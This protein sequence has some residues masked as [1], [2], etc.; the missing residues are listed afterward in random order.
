V[1]AEERRLAREREQA[2]RQRQWEAVIE[3]AKRRFLADHRR[4]VLGKRVCAWQEAD[5]IRAYCDAVEV[6]YGAVIVATD[7][8]ASEWLAYAREHATL[9]QALPRTPADSDVSLEAF[10][11]YLCGLSP[12]GPK[13]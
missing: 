12:Y 1:E 6:R 10:K 7:P 5:V 2:E 3:D 9:L 11:S 8:G 4:D 13:S